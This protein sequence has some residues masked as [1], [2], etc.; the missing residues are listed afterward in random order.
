M[1][2]FLSDVMLDQEKDA[3]GRRVPIPFGKGDTARCS[4]R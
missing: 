1:C 3:T 4:A 2:V